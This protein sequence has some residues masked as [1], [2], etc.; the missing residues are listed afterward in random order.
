MTTNDLVDIEIKLA[1]QD[2]KIESLHTALVD[3]EKRLTS[4]EEQVARLE[5]ALRIVAQRQGS[6][7]QEVAGA[8]PE[9]DP[10]PRSG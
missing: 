5:K 1:W 3:K 4:L 2:E 6:P 9:E 7:E 10:V 8:H